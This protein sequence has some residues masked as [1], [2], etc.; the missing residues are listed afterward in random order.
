MAEHIVNERGRIRRI[1][2]EPDARD[3]RRARGEGLAVIRSFDSSQRQ[4]GDGRRPADLTESRQAE[5]RPQGDLRGRFVDRSADDEV[6]PPFR[7][8]AR[9]VQ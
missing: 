8:R 6:R 5:R 1:L 4:H 9:F 3:S 7:R 2:K